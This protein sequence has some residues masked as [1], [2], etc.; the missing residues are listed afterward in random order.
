M[1][2]GALISEAFRVTIRNRYL[3]FF[4]FF[5]GGNFSASSPFDLRSSE[6]PLS[7]SASWMTWAGDNI[8]AVIIVAIAVAIL[9]TLVSSFLWIVSQGSLPGS[10]AAIHRGEQDNFSSAW[11]AGLSRFWQVAGLYLLLSLIWAGILLAIVIPTGLVIWSVL[12]AT[13]DIVVR[14]LLITLIVLF[15][16]VL[17]LIAFVPL[18][19]VAAFALRKLTVDGEGIRGSLRGGYNLFRRTPDQ[20]LLIWILELAL[21]IGAGTGM[22]VVVLLL[23]LL[24]SIPVTILYAAGYT[25]AA[26]VITVLL[27]LPIVVLSVVLSGVLGAFNSSYWTLAY[28]QLTRRETA[29]TPA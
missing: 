18:G 7:R 17:L 2:Y 29:G 3:W 9:L 12:A 25:I 22:A 20:S 8:L 4:G 1:N 26:V 6:E 28:L 24:F 10:V 27:G 13:Q 15:A 5:S 23:V 16:L 11:R 19:I 14:I 21:L